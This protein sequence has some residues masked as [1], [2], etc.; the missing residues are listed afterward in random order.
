MS[1][2][3]RV[4]L[5]VLVGDQARVDELQRLVGLD[6]LKQDRVIGVR[7]DAADLGRAAGLAD[8]VVGAAAVVIRAAGREAQAGS[9]RQA[10][11]E[12]TT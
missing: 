3:A 2:G 12:C 6:G 5:G 10:T 4:A 9:G 1:S 7:Q 8:A 11:D